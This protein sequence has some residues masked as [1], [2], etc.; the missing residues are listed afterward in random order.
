MVAPVAGVIRKEPGSSYDLREAMKRMG[1]P[2]LVIQG[3]Q[4]PM[5]PSNAYELH[6]GIPGSKLAFIEKAGH[7]PWVEQPEAT[8]QALESFL[9][10][11]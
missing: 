2:T 1:R 4:D 7:F 6:L 8:F 9:P 11:R 10:Q 5:D 3:R